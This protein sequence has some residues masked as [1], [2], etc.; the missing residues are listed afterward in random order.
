MNNL[1]K[2][3]RIAGVVALAG[4]VAGIIGTVWYA[5]DGKSVVG[6]GTYV[7]WGLWV[8]VY[9]LMIGASGGA[10]LVYFLATSLGVRQLRPLVPVA[11]P[12][13]IGSLAGG[14]FAIW[15]DLA[16]LERFWHLFVFTDFGSVMGLMVWL[17]AIFGVLLVA[18]HLLVRTRGLDDPLLK[19]LGWV[20]LALFIVF[21]GA[22]GSLFGVVSAQS[23]WAGGLTPVLFITEGALA[24][25]AAVIAAAVLFGPAYEDWSRVLRPLL[26]GL[27]ITVLV[28]QW[29]KYSTAL[30]AGV[31]STLTAVEAV[32]FGDFW[33]V[34][35]IVYLLGGVVLPLA[36][37]TFARRSTAA[38]GAAAALVTITAIGPK[39]NLVIP[40]L[41][42]PD[43]EELRVAYTGPGLSFEYFPTLVEWL[44][45]V[46]AVAIAALVFLVGRTVFASIRRKAPNR[47]LEPTGP[48]SPS[49]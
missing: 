29:A 39:L 43:F 42:V 4:L 20:G 1:T 36:L 27:I 44:V 37:L 8:A 35:W 33:W 32:L 12:V 21:G 48:S 3:E 41:T 34:F 28:L 16:R 40:A 38:V 15:V 23:L 17:Y 49:A 14:L 24:G 25:V 7:P 6:Y 46:G 45:T 9:A 5:I 11:L 2:A 47:D 26:I 30:Y 22:E 13:A 19:T 31:P 18:L 10:F